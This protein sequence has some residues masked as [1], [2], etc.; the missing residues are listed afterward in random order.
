MLR[1]LAVL[2]LLSCLAA[3]ACCQDFEIVAGGEGQFLVLED[4]PALEDLPANGDKQLF[5]RG[6]RFRGVAPAASSLTDRAASQRALL[7]QTLESMQ[8]AYFN[9][10]MKNESEIVQQQILQLKQHAEVE[11]PEPPVDEE[12]NLTP[13]ELR[14]HVGEVHVVAATG[15][16]N[17]NVWGSGI[18]TDDSNIGTA[19]VHA[20]V[21]ESGES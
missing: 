2:W 14:E 21:L 8:A 6:F 20:G 1:Q 16:E 17:G 10:G 13:I 12:A 15:T 18:Y 9:A 3:E 4:V 19:A 11:L 5:V 7:I